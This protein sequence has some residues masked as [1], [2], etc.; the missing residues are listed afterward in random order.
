MIGEFWRITTSRRILEYHPYLIIL[1]DH[2]SKRRNATN[3]N[4]DVFRPELAFRPPAGQ[5]RS[6]LKM[7]EQNLSTKESVA[8]SFFPNA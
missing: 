5:L 1:S 3:I 8:Q 4:S 7:S 6:K 2:V